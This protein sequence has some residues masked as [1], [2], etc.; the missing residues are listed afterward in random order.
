LTADE[1][2]PSHEVIEA[3]GGEFLPMAD[4][5]ADQ[6]MMGEGNRAVRFGDEV[7]R[8]GSLTE[9]VAAAI[10]SRMQWKEGKDEP[11]GRTF[12]QLTVALFPE[13][14]FS[15]DDFTPERLRHYYEQVVPV[16]TKRAL[17]DVQALHTDGWDLLCSNGEVW[18]EPPA[19]ECDIY[20]EHELPSHPKLF[21]SSA[22]A[23]AYAAQLEL[24]E[25]EVEQ[26][27][28]DLTQRA[29]EDGDSYFAFTARNRNGG[30]PPKWVEAKHGAH[31]YFEAPD[32]TQWIAQASSERFRITGSEIEW[33]TVEVLDPDYGALIT[34]LGE[35]LQQG[36]DGLLTI[37]TKGTFAGRHFSGA[38]NVWILSALNAAKMIMD[39]RLA[40][41]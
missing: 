39:A 25:T 36:A 13:D 12:Q 9:N 41:N 6:E 14:G 17:Q 30:Q 19:D 16:Y 35:T 24:T 26:V 31:F 7:Y 1:G 37:I 33:D 27:Q 3:C 5:S 34:E 15:G 40:E 22:E 8:E 18:A 23:K 11:G 10:R 28:I 20:A 4:P 21:P 29:R 38:V 2:W 32:G